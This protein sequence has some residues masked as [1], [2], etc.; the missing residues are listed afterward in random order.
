MAR[1]TRASD[2]RVRVRQA[3]PEYFEWRLQF[4]ICDQTDMERT[5]VDLAKRYPRKFNAGEVTAE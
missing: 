1:E 2:A 4:T 3:Q 5:L